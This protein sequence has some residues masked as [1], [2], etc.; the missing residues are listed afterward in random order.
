ML[1]ILSVCIQS[2]SHGVASN[3]SNGGRDGGGG[4][5]GMGGGFSGVRGRT[6]LR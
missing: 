3:G 1:N 2:H 5:G 4:G 6:F